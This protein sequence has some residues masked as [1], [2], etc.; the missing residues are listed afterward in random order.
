MCNAIQGAVG[1]C[2]NADPAG[3]EQGLGATVEDEVLD[4]ASCKRERGPLAPPSVHL[5]GGSQELGKAAPNGGLMYDAI[6]GT[7]GEPLEK[8]RSWIMQ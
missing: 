2:D 5:G 3:H 6:Q 4:E 7:V 1:Q 8:M